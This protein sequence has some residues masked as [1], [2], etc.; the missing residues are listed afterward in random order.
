MSYEQGCDLVEENAVINNIPPEVFSYNA[1]PGLYTEYFRDT[2]PTAQPFF[3][4]TNLLNHTNWFY[5]SRQP[6]F[7]GAADLQSIRWTGTLTPSETGMYNIIMKSDGGF[8]LYIDGKIIL[9]HWSVHDL[10]VDSTPLQ[11]EQGTAYSFKLEYFQRSRRPQLLVQWQVLN[12]DHVQRAVELAKNSDA[13]IFVGGITSQLEGEEMRVDYEGF[14]GGDRTSLDLPKVQEQLLASLSSTGTPIILVLTSGSALSINWEKADIPAIVQLWY[15][16]EEGGTALADVLF[17]DY[18]PAGRLPITFYKSVDQLP[19]FEDYTMAGRTYRYF[20]GEP[21]YSFGFGLSY[22]TFAYSDLRI[23]EE[24]KTSDSVTVS[25]EVRNAG[26]VAGDEVV[27]LYLKNLT[28]AVPVPIHALQGFKRIQLKPGERQVVQF[29]LRPKQFALITGEEQFVVEP[30]N[31]E[32]TVGGVLPG[33]TAPTTECITK[34]IR[35]VGK[36]YRIP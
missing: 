8:R 9:E 36:P 35:I 19:P 4:R 6:S 28:A 16:G 11:L 15:P 13:V 18:N 12:I 10:A 2:D 29:T 5:G 34:K 32:I 25:V 22:T 33:V 30:N 27:Q 17:G 21:L 7:D 14:K 24:I 1:Q 31:Y 23:P 20:A 26:T 3:S